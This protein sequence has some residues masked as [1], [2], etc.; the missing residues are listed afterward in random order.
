MSKEYR[1]FTLIELLIVVAIIGILAAI[2]V[3][4]FMNART[5]AKVARVRSELRSLAVAIDSYQLDQ[6]EFPWPKYNSRFDTANHIANCTE[7]TSP[8]SYMTTVDMD[9]PFVPRDFW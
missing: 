7:L 6:N 8:I 2:A 1:G 9:D 3:P 4:N 5:R